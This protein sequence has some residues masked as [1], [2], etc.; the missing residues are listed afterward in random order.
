[1][2]PI[3]QFELHNVA[4]RHAFRP[5]VKLCLDP[6]PTIECRER[7]LHLR[8]CENWQNDPPSFNLETGIKFI[9]IP[10]GQ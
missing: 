1:M 4:N 2:A 5:F 6:P 3:I 7:Y 9:P 10:Q 8:G